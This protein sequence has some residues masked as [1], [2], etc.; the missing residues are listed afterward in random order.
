M[1]QFPNIATNTLY[2]RVPAR[3]DK[4]IKFKTNDTILINQD[5]YKVLYVTPSPTLNN[6]E[7]A[8]MRIHNKHPFE[9]GSLVFIKYDKSSWIYYNKIWIKI[10]N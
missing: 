2:K 10:L 8:Q 7:F 5:I 1:I 3:L 9:N 6:I 4:N